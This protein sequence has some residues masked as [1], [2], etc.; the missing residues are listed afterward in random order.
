MVPEKSL[1]AGV[2]SQLCHLLIKTILRFGTNGLYCV[3]KGNMVFR[4]FCFSCST[5]FLSVNLAS[6]RVFSTMLFG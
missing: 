3:T 4:T 2:V 6:A 1:E 5:Y